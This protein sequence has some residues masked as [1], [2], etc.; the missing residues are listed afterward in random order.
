MTA[1]S[2]RTR[3]NGSGARRSKS[4]TIALFLLPALALYVLFVLIPI[5]QAGHYSLY[6]WNGLQ[7]L[8][9][10]IGLKNYETALSSAPFRAAIGNN[11]LIIVLSLAIQIPFSLALAV[12]LNRRFPGRAVFRLLFFLPYVLSE[13]VTGIVF[14]LLLQPD[15]FVD[16]AMSTVGLGA[17]VQDWFGDTN[18]VMITMF[19]IISWKYFGF[20]MILMLAGLQGIPKELEEAA[21]IDGADKRQAFR[22]VTLPLLGPT[23]RVSV[24]LSMIGALQLFDMIWVMTAGGPLNASNTMAISMF[25]A[26]FK[27]TQMGYGSA[28]AVI[29]FLFS[30]VVALAYQRFV[31]RRDTEGALTT[32][33][34]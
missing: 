7:P 26:G 17:L 8:T 10:F 27:G 31:L 14:R 12:M 16:S 5:V 6:K 23:I 24:F 28:L 21:L 13:A 1:L 2:A 30:L 29:L 22:H 4:L 18:V 15:A 32:F 33:G 9:D 19:V 34:G 25:K 3:G 20:H 11:V